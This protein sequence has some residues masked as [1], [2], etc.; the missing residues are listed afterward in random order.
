MENY[1]AHDEQSVTSEIATNE[2]QTLLVRVGFVETDE[3]QLIRQQADLAAASYD[4][5]SLSVLLQEYQR[6]GEEYVSMFVGDEYI[7]GQ[8]GLIVATATLK[9]DV[10]NIAAF[11]TDIADAKDYAYDTYQDE[12]VSLLEKLPSLEI[13]RIL[14]GLGEEYGFDDGTI[15]DI[16]SEPYDTGFE[17]AYGY[18]TRAGLDADEILGAFITSTEL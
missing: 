4:N 17:V 6:L 5:E 7:R 9:R 14:S 2:T 3:L 13:A 10:G 1:T 18:I 15:A 16:V 8:I 11:L 12:L